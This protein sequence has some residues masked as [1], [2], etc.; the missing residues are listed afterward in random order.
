MERK[1][2]WNEVSKSK[3]TQEDGEVNAFH[4]AWIDEDINPK[5]IRVG[6]VNGDDKFYS[7]KWNNYHDCYESDT[8]IFPTHWQ[9]LPEPPKP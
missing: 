1:D 3:L 9:P 6:F 2:N 4:P 8:V 7:A 5:G